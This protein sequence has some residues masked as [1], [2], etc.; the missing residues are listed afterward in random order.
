MNKDS[1][2]KIIVYGGSGLVGSRIVELLSSSFEIIAPSHSEVDLLN[3][4]W[5]NKYSDSI[6]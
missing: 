3:K 6:F 1:K 5:R 4:N 2:R